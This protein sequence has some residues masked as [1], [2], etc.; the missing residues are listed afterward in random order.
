MVTYICRVGDSLNM[1]KTTI[2]EIETGQ[3]YTSFNYSAMIQKADDV[4]CIL[5]SDDYK[6]GTKVILLHNGNIKVT[7]TKYSDVGL[8]LRVQSCWQKRR[9]RT[10]DI[11]HWDVVRAIVRASDELR[12]Y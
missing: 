3:E 6:I 5:M 9:Y 1:S 10:Y 7:A 2:T 12:G 8:T 4:A 11:T